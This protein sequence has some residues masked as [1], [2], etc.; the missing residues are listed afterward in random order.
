MMFSRNVLGGVAMTALTEVRRIIMNAARRAATLLVPLVIALVAVAQ[1]A[2]VT[3]DQTHRP[4]LL[5]KTTQPG[6]YVELPTVRTEIS[7]QIRGI[8]ARALVKQTFENATDHC[9]EA[10]YVFPLADNA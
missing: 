3:L 2:P 5:V 10:V 4:A 6:V 8:L 7:V 9:V 1:E